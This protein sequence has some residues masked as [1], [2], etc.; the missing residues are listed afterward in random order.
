MPAVSSTTSLTGA[1]AS[2]TAPTYLGASAPASTKEKTK[3]KKQKK[4][5]E[6]RKKEGN[7]G[8]KNWTRRRK[9]CKGASRVA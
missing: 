2:A 9:C 4:K 5:K 7:K 8:K 3:K 1:P 6:V